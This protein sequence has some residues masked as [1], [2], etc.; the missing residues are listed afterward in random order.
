[1]TGSSMD[2][3]AGGAAALSVLA[4]VVTAGVV[5]ALSLSGV[6]TFWI[7]LGVGLVGFIA[8]ATI[9]AAVEVSRR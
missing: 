1:M 3:Q 9:L 4:V 2:E 6:A 5:M 7:A 8:A